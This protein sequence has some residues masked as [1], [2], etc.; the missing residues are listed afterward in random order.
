MQSLF[1]MFWNDKNVKGVTYWGYI[2][3]ET[4]ETNTWLLS[5]GGTERSAMSWLMQFVGR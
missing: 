1:T 3:G 4:W 2:Q 5:T